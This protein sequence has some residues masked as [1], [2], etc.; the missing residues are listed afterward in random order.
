VTVRTLTDDES[1]ATTNATGEAAAI[2][3]S[4]ESFG[5]LFGAAVASNLADGIGRTAVP[6]IALTLSDDPVAISIITALS[7]LPWLLFGI[8]A[9]VIVDRIDRRMAMA[10]A[11]GIRVLVAI[12]LTVAIATD[13]LSMPMLYFAVIAFGLGETLADNATNALIPA[14]VG[15][16]S[17]DRANGRIQGAQIGIDH[18][19]A[20]PI[21]GML[22]GIAVAVP[23]VTAAGGY[24]LAGLLALA[25]PEAVGQGSRSPQGQKRAKVTAMEGIRYLAAHPY[26]RTMA[27]VTS[28]LGGLFQFGQATMLLAFV[29]LWGV[30]PAAFG[31][32]AAAIGTGAVIGALLAPVAVT[33]WGRGRV[34]LAG[35]VLGT[36]GLG[37]AGFAANL[38]EAL[39]AYSLGALGISMWN[40]PWGSLRQLLIPSQLLGRVI[41][42]MRTISWGLYPIA[43][44]LGGWMGR[45]SLR[46]PFVLGAAGALVVTLIAARLFLSA[47]RQVPSE[48]QA[49]LTA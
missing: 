45:F 5:R 2:S 21:G 40:V 43:T 18:F 23:V 13:A 14:A 42:V 33:R 46:A 8:P 20:M 26:L 12:G 32:V 10:A 17:L 11:N 36:V 37:A 4:S 22:L 47:D 27:I 35:A 9:G 39:I 28:I 19:V 49:S 16:G 31:F 44:V 1:S 29:R 25:L 7:F 48:P 41:G 34:M 38:L 3:A 6:L 24:L 30:Q 15:S